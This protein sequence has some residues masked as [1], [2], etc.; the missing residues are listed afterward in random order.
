MP[1]FFAYSLRRRSSAM[2]TPTEPPGRLRVAPGPCAGSRRAGSRRSCFPVVRV[3]WFVLA[4]A[5]PL[6][7]PGQQ[8]P[9]GRIQTPRAIVLPPKVLAGS[10]A[11]LAVID[12]AGRLVPRVELEVTGGQTIM[13][14]ATGRASFLVPRDSA[15]LT[16]RIAKPAL[17]A[18]APAELPA[19]QPGTAEGPRIV[20]HPNFISLRD[21]F[22]IQGSGFRGDA[23]VNQV[24]L[25]DQ[26][27]AVLAAS[28]V[29]LIVL[30]APRVPPGAV[31]LRVI[32]GDGETVPREVT[33]VLLEV[34]GPAET[35]VVG[36][37]SVAT[38]HVRGTTERLALEVRHGSPAVIEFVRGN[39]HR[40]T[41][42]GGDS[43]TAE[44]R[45]KSLAPGDYTITARL[46][47]TASGLPDLQT[48]RQKLVTARE[49]AAPAWAAR[50]DRLIRR[51][52]RAP[53]DPGRIRAELESMRSENPPVEFA[54]LL[55][56]ASQDM[57]AK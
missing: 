8:A 15:W 37:E 29:A 20:S 55:E 52:D 24:F 50:L 54:S 53:Q 57:T 36:A 35:P 30:A 31:G 39:P 56:S 32:V 11:T 44:V 9:Q 13:T 14:D 27:C 49:R 25:G 22:V 19:E 18:S 7:L 28:P 38:V 1:S 26:R 10:P 43:N 34:S 3:G 45:M 46:I 23:D 5:I 12:G 16:A 4:C 48:V 21:R 47:P 41:S 17:S 40:L 33:A 51:I 2:P 42:S 6:A